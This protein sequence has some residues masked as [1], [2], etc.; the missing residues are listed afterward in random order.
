MGLVGVLGV[1]DGECTSLIDLRSV[2]DITTEKNQLE[3]F[4]LIKY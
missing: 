1:T 3:Q 2:I 4:R